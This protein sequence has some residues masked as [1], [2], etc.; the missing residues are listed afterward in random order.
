MMAIAINNGPI[1][2]PKSKLKKIFP[3]PR[4]N[5]IV[6]PIPRNKRANVKNMMAI[7]NGFRAAPNHG[8]VNFFCT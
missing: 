6:N 4:K 7:V 8:D 2:S 5:N 1:I 3:N